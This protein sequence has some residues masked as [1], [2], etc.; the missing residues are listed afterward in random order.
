MA[1]TAQQRKDRRLG[2]GGSDIAAIL[3]ISKWA[4]PLDIYLEK[5]STEEPEDDLGNPFTE[6]GN[7]LEPV[8]IKKFE[9]LTNI[10]C[11]TD[12][13]TFIHP[14]YP[15]M[16]ANID[17]K[18]IGEDAILE[19][20]TAGQF[21]GKEWSDLGAD[22]IPEPY[23]L[24]CAFYAEVV[25]CARVYIA[26]LIGGND[27]R[28]YHYDRNPA[29]GKL[30]L[31][32]VT[33]FWENNVLKEIPPMPVNYNDALKLWRTTETDELKL[34]TDEIL[35]TLKELRSLKTDK[36]NIEAQLNLKQMELYNFMQTAQQINSHAGDVLVTWKTQ[37]INKFDAARFKVEH[38][39]LYALYIKTMQSRVLRIKGDRE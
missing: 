3:G 37:S 18:L 22:N 34:A 9:D 15:Y 5:L 19:C 30:I 16:R 36:R 27:F 28:V 11:A 1:L 29:L 20:K 10:Q 12:M 17:G 26:V 32:K 33:D 14:E 31:A 21:A 13:D 23:L 6:W 35:K 2:V 24:Q 7:R 4:T 25:G 39:E 38:P 8:I